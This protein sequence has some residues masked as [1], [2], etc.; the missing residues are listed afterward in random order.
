MSCTFE[1]CWTSNKF[2]PPPPPKWGDSPSSQSFLPPPFFSLSEGFLAGS[3][4]SCL[5]WSLCWV[6][7]AFSCIFL[8]VSPDVFPWKIIFGYKKKAAIHFFPSPSL[9]D[10]I[11][12]TKIFCWQP[13][14]FVRFVFLSSIQIL[15]KSNRSLSK[16][17]SDYQTECSPLVCIFIF[18]LYFPLL[19]PS[20]VS[21]PPFS[22]KNSPNFSYTNFIHLSI[23]L[24]LSLPFSLFFPFR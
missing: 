4:L 21:P 11:N 15:L 16:L 3:R 8:S 24:S 10:L 12:E 20:P 5:F 9:C 6:M 14:D 18:V 22:P 1:R 19:P 17:V 7:R 23:T 2:G 13:S